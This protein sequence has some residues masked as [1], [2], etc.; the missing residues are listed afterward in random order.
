MRFDDLKTKIFENQEAIGRGEVNFLSMENVFPKLKGYFPGFIKSDYALISA[1][2]SIGKSKFAYFLV[3][4]LLNLRHKLPSLSLKIFYNSLEEPV[5]KFMAIFKMM[6]LK[7]KYGIQISYYN[8]MGYSMNQFDPK[9]IP[10]IVEASEFCKLHVEPYLEVV[11][12]PQTIGFYKLVRNHLA[13]TGTFYGIDGKPIEKMGDMWITYKPHNPSHWVVAVSDHIGNYLEEPGKSKYETIGNFSAY[14][15]RQLLGLK[16]GVV[17]IIVQQQ[18]A[19]KEAL[20]VNVKGKTLIDK[21]KP[22]LDGLA[23]NK[24]TQR[25]ATVAIGLFSPFKWKD[26]LPN[27]MYNGFDLDVWK[28]NL[29]MLILLK[30]REAESA[31]DERELPVYFDGGLSEFIELDSSDMSHNLTILNERR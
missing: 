9:L 8:L 28:N 11:S 2:T 3:K 5:E 10:L 16:C 27:A 12:I 6:Y 31:L 21:M 20:E 17:S 26:H 15:T 18:V 4:H 19:A 23:E 30:S 25:D 24:S 7:R 22:S 29:R 1:S 14:Y 13:D